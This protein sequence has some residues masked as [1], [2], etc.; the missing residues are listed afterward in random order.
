MTLRTVCWTILV[1]T[2]VLLTIPVTVNRRCRQ[3]RA[4]TPSI[5]AFSIASLVGMLAL[6]SANLFD[7]DSTRGRFGAPCTSFAGAHSFT[8]SYWSARGR[9][10]RFRH[11]PPSPRSLCKLQAFDDLSGG[12]DLLR[13]AGTGDAPD[14][15]ATGRLGATAGRVNVL[16][17]PQVAVDT[18][19]RFRTP[20]R[21]RERLC[22]PRRVAGATIELQFTVRCSLR[23][24]FREIPDGV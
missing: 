3:N 19:G 18:H 16:S 4:P 11:S 2:A 10:E 21:A 15:Y 1:A 7:F 20:S 12:L 6:A 24:T 23:T 8:A 22:R 9:G 5:P 13:V 14:C 17:P